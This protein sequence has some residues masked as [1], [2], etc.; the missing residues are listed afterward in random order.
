MS[1][2]ILVGN[3]TLFQFKPKWLLQSPSA[4]AGSVRCRTCAKAART[5]AHRIRIGEKPLPSYCPLDLLSKNE[6]D[7]HRV[8]SILLGPDHSAVALKHLVHW[9]KTTSILPRLRQLQEKLDS[10]GVLTSSDLPDENLLIAMTLRDCN[11][12]I[13]FPKIFLKNERLEAKIGDL[14]LKSG[15]KVGYWKGWEEKLSKEGWYTGEEVE[16]QELS[17]TLAGKKRV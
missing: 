6:S 3:E 4:P 13:K 11:V 7:L 17:C 12:Y 16:K 14:D 8:A 5:N 9:L 1:L 10:N 2:I 15:K